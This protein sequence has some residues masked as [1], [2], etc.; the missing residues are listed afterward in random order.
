MTSKRVKVLSLI[1]SA[2]MLFSIIGSMGVSAETAAETAVSEYSTVKVGIDVSYYQG[3]IDWAQ[4]KNEVDFAIL[5]VGYTGYGNLSI[6]ADV[7]FDEYVKGAS[8]A[9]IPIGIYYFGSATS[10]EMAVREANFVLEQLAKYP[11]TFSYPII[12]DI[13]VTDE[14]NSAVPPVATA[15]SKAFCD[16]VRAAGYYPMVY[17]YTSYFNPYIT[18]ADISN[19]DFWQ[20]HYYTSYSGKTPAQ[21]IEK[22]GNRPSILGNYDSNISIWQCTSEGVV[23]GISGDVD[24]NIS[25]FDYDAFIKNEGYNGYTKT[26]SDN[27]IATCTGTEVNVRSGASTAFDVVGT[28]KLGEE[29]KVK[30]IYNKTWLEIEFEGEI[31]YVHSDYFTISDSSDS[32]VSG[33]VRYVICGADGVNVYLSAN[34]ADEVIGTANSGDV[35]LVVE[36]LGEWIKIQYNGTEAYVR[37][38]DVTVSES[39]PETD[40]EIGDVTDDDEG[41]TEEKPQ[42]IFQKAWQAIVNFFKS[43]GDFFKNLFGGKK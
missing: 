32:E 28:A 18:T 43:I 21:L 9:G 6:N 30:R 26:A 25:Y 39:E 5:R 29:F 3:D 2:V 8:E 14:M 20:A 17:S 10:T 37:T 16:T 4:V 31:A 27:R 40:G 35:F 11:A 7:K 41:E 24:V 36:D 22:S 38:A 13:E 12:Y 42:N 15:V 19:N 23:S 34:T 33:T 1:L